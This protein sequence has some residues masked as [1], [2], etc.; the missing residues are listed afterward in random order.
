MGSKLQEHNGLLGLFQG[1]KFVAKTN[2]SVSVAGH[3]GGKNKT[4]LPGILTF[5]LASSKLLF[6]NCH[7]FCHFSFL[8]LKLVP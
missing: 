6:S 5:L 1:E 3:T 7:F 8:Y 2:F 4:D